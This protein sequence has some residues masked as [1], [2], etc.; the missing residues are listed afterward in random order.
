M[1]FKPLYNP[2]NEQLHFTVC[3]CTCTLVPMCQAWVHDSPPV[4]VWASR[5]RK[6]GLEVNLRLVQFIRFLKWCGSSRKRQVEPGEL[7]TELQH[8]QLGL[9]VA[10]HTL[11]KTKQIHERFLT[12]GDII[13]VV[14]AALLP[15]KKRKQT[16][17]SCVF[18]ATSAFCKY[19]KYTAGKQY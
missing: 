11:W 19:C 17:V 9:T 8:Q 12:A 14:P 10:I 1:D 7:N 3:V 6:M 18:S 16:P 5:E 15:F 4:M 2:V 13:N